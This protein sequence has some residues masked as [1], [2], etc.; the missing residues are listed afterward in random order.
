M[1]A[2][3]MHPGYH[4]SRLARAS[5]LKLIEAQ[6][7]HAHIASVMAEHGLSGPVIGLA[8]DGTGYGADGNV[9]G[10]EFLVCEGGTFRRRAHLGYV[11]LAGGDSVAV[12]ARKAALCYRAAAGLPHEQFEGS[13][14]LESALRKGIN[15]TFYSG[16]GRLFDAVSSMLGFCHWNGYEGECAIALE[17]AAHRA[18][19]S[20]TKPL[21]MEFGTGDSG[22]IDLL[23]VLQTICRGSSGHAKRGRRRRSASTRPCAAWR[24]RFVRK[25]GTEEGVETVALSGGTFQ[26]GLILSGCIRLLRGAGFKVY[27]NNEVPCNDGG[28]ALGQAFIAAMQSR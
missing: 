2:C 15:T 5:G 10:G 24:L 26:N 21:G 28:L 12:D 4:S 16:M 11:K 20:A 22:E 18:V 7:H 3:D 23:P 19:A 1:A 25:Y 13:E 27:T 17:N 14:L 9:W 8:F 6:H